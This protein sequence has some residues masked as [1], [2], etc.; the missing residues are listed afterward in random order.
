MI[1][2]MLSKNI[3]SFSQ[4][5]EATRV[6][7]VTEPILKKCKEIDYRKRPSAEEIVSEFRKALKLLELEDFS[8]E[9][10]VPEN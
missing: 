5:L 4:G 10:E 6:L 9:L 3:L 7:L 2:F 8:K 1:I